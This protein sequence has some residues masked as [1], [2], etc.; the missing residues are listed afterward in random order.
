MPCQIDRKTERKVH[1]NRTY[2]TGQNELVPKWW[3]NG[4]V[5]RGNLKNDAIFPSINQN[6]V[7]KTF[8]LQDKHVDTSEQNAEDDGDDAIILT[9][10]G[11]I[12]Q[13]I[14]PK[15]LQRCYVQRCRSNIKNRRE[16]INHYR[17]TH[18]NT[19]VLCPLCDKPI[20]APWPNKYKLHFDRIHPNVAIPFDFKG[21][22]NDSAK[23]KSQKRKVSYRIC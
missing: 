14:W 3:R 21:T 20:Y 6:K 7:Q 2:S 11:Q 12:T 16:A 22:L 15:D 8:Q 17:D 5:L 13:W 18:A 1:R 23:L 10:C 9:G 4:S 19:A